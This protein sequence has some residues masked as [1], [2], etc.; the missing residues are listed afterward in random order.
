M[1][2]SVDP[3]FTEPSA[4]FPAT[5]GP[6]LAAYAPR[7]AFAPLLRLDRYLDSLEVLEKEDR[8]NWKDEESLC[9]E[10][11]LLVREFRSEGEAKERPDSRFFELTPVLRRCRNA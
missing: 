2:D 10:R 1:V 4:G 8:R 6:S 11:S 9:Q 3:A 7:E 5:T